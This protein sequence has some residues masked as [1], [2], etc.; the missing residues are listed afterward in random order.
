M[1]RQLY[2]GS[3]RS[4][5]EMAMA[6]SLAL[7]Q[8][9][10]LRKGILTLMRR[11]FPQEYM[12]TERKTGRP[13]G[14]I[15][16]DVLLAYLGMFMGALTSVERYITPPGAAELREAL[17]ARGIDVP[18]GS[19][20]A[21]WAA[22]I[23]QTTTATPPAPPQ[24]SPTPLLPEPRQQTPAPQDSGTPPRPRRP[25]ASTADDPGELEDLFESDEAPPPPRT[26][27]GRRDRAV[28]QPPPPP[29]E[30][31]PETLSDADLESLFG[32]DPEYALDALFD[33]TIASLQ[34]ID[35][36]EL[37]APPP[38]PA[39]PGPALPA[40]STT[41]AQDTDVSQTSE[42]ISEVVISP[43]ALRPQL[44]PELFPG[45][46]IPR[47]KSRK[48]SNRTPRTQAL[49][50]DPTNFDVP[51]AAKNTA[52]EV[53]NEADAALLNAVKLPRPMFTSDLIPMAGSHEVVQAWE[54]RCRNEPRSALRFVP[55]KARHRDLGSLVLP[56]ADKRHMPNDFKQSLWGKLQ[57]YK[58]A[59][60]YELGVILR[61]V[62][63]DVVSHHVGNG[64][65]TLRLSQPRGLVGMVLVTAA[66]I[67]EGTPAHTEFVDAVD[68]LLTERLSSVVTLMV[69]DAMMESAV[70]TLVNAAALRGWSPTMPVI[71]AYSWEYASDQG[72]TAT[73]VL[74]S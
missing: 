73:L 60:I 54:E 56:Y 31:G 37:S 40:K 47:A 62:G 61:K 71:A 26:R 64:V 29:Q 48:G 24:P 70:N 59:R 15:E 52:P 55:P 57:H 2:E 72:K 10:R 19:D 13:L 39:A 53:P 1:Y 51:T 9:K 44:R 38:D 21:A 35:A 17:A 18:T 22:V 74:G 33:D 34:E 3:Q 45:G 30:Q 16:D 42:V 49:P 46:G 28:A 43:P 63:E 11:N 4:L 50:A 67:T 27:T 66:D 12:A 36:A 7:A 68:E 69:N 23:T 5:T 6:Q 32:P 8:H 58:R 25:L 14:D 41:T 20:L 65:V